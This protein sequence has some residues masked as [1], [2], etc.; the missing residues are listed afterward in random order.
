VKELLA[1][2]ARASRIARHNFE[3][4]RRHLS[5]EVLRRRLGRWIGKLTHTR[6]QPQ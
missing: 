3:L 4:A 6:Q 2:P 1:D 5:Y